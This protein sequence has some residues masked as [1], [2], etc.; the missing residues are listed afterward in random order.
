MI[1][2]LKLILNLLRENRDVFIALGNMEEFSEVGD[3]AF[4]ILCGYNDLQTQS[5]RSRRAGRH[6]RMSLFDSD[7]LR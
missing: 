7:G 1:Q 5:M 4:A 6:F 3:L 2:A